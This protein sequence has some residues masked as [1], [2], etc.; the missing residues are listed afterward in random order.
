MKVLLHT[1]CCPCLIKCYETLKEEKIIPTIFWYNPNIHPWMEYNLRKDALIKYTETEN[2]ELVINDNYGLRDF[3]KSI[4]PDFTQKRCNYCYTSR[5]EE[6]AKYASENGY[7]YFS[8]TLLISPYQ[9]HELIKKL[10]YDIA[11]KYS[12]KFLYRDFRPYFREGQ[13]AARELGVY[14]QKY[15]GCV[16]SEEE[17]YNSRSLRK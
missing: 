7:E 2:L 8:T 9:N 14:M 1:C 5:L 16:F 17:R 15:C 4:Y 13:K 3:I 6:T 11:L 10:G 12:V